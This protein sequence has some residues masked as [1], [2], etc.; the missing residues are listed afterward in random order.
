MATSKRERELLNKIEDARYR[1][2]V[3]RRIVT[4]WTIATSAGIGGL[5]LDGG[6]YVLAWIVVGGCLVTAFVTLGVIAGEVSDNHGE[7]PGK[8]LRDA[9]QAYTDF[10]WER[11]TRK[12]EGK[13]G[14]TT[15]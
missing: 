2:S 1:N 12:T 11:E 13:N 15:E 6:F 7:W 4:A 10:V 8:R 3:W 9:R 14:T 5:L